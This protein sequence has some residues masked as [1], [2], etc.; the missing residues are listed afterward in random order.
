MFLI[1]RSGKGI[2][3]C[4]EEGIFVELHSGKGNRELRDVGGTSKGKSK[5]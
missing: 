3:K 2:T 1:S 5:H 4:E